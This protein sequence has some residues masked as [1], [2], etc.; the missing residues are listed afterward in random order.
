MPA[1]TRPG[2]RGYGRGL[3]PAGT[4]ADTR[5][6]PTG[7]DIRAI[8]KLARTRKPALTCGASMRTYINQLLGF[9]ISHPIP[10]FPPPQH[11]RSNPSPRCPPPAPESRDSQRRV[12]RARLVTV[13]PA[14]P[15]AIPARGRRLAGSSCSQ[16]PSSTR[17]APPSLPSPARDLTPSIPVDGA[18]AAIPPFLPPSWPTGQWRRAFRRRRT[19]SCGGAS[20]DD[21]DG[22]V[23]ASASGGIGGL[24]HSG[25]RRSPLAS[26][27]A[28]GA[29][30]TPDAGFPVSAP[31]SPPCTEAS[32]PAVVFPVLAGVRACQRECFGRG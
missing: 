7:I 6:C 1:G 23:S 31:A 25:S 32:L 14:P 26:P 27:L 21:G 10:R 13:L 2:G 18:T 8:K 29:S 28:D 24:L 4:G 11:R 15:P 17:H 3:V 9:P 22:G 30:Q 16:S 20:P 19:R 5:L 12:A